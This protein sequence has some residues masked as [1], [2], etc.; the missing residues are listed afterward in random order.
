MRRNG[1][2]GGVDAR[3]L[4]GVAISRDIRSDKNDESSADGGDDSE[5][6]RSTTYGPLASGQPKYYKDTHHVPE[7]HSLVVRGVEG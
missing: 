4:V 6:G 7:Y 3:W 2:A 1:S 5:G